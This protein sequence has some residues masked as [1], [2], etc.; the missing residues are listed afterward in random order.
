MAV[1]GGRQKKTAR[2]RADEEQIRLNL[3]K[4]REEEQRL[5]HTQLADRSG[6]T[7]DFIGKIERGERG[8]SPISLAR[9]AKALGH[10]VDDFFLPTPPPY[11]PRKI[12]PF[13]VHTTP[14]I[15]LDDSLDLVQDVHRAVAEANAAYY[16]RRGFH[17][18]EKRKGDLQS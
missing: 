5:S 13:V 15:D 11:D 14:G 4:F 9:L 2:Q 16:A 10:S 18:R 3:K 17:R 12:P 8:T 1:R 7:A 6:L